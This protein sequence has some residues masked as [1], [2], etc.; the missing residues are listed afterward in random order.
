[1]GKRRL[2]RLRKDRKIAEAK[3]LAKHNKWHRKILRW[4]KSLFK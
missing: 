2:R 4:L 1:M 3:A